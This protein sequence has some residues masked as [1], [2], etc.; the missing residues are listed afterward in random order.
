AVLA[1]Q[2]S[3]C[4]D[5]QGKFWPY[6]DIL[7]KSQQA[8]E[9]KDLEGYA[10]KLKIDMTKFRQCLDSGEKFAK[11]QK[12]ISEGDQAGVNATPTFFI[13]GKIVVGDIPQEQIEELINEEL[14]R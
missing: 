6:H 14:K 8:L 13:N 2:A 7:F 11:V 9:R 3:L 10:E 12:D 1:H 4:A 5:D